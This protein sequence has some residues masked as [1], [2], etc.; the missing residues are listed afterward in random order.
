MIKTCLN[1][2][3][4]IN[5]KNRWQKWNKIGCPYTIWV[6]KRF[7]G[8]L[9]YS[10]SLL[11]CIWKFAQYMSDGICWLYFS[12]SVKDETMVLCKQETVNITLREKDS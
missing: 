7:I 1:L 5:N 2:K 8:T 12:L 6:G 10:L 3:L 11:V 9:Y 4:V